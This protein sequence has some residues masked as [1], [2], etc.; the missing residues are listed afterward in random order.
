MI[1]N[2]D[3]FKNYCYISRLQGLPGLN[4]GVLLVAVVRWWLTEDQRHLTYL[5]PGMK[6]NSWEKEHPGSLG[7][8]LNLYVGCLWGLSRMLASAYQISYMQAQG[9]KDGCFQREKETEIERASLWKLLSS[10]WP[11][12]GSCQVLNIIFIRTESLNPVYIQGEDNY[13]YGYVLKLPQSG[14]LNISDP[15]LIKVK[16]SILNNPYWEI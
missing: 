13:I 9:S 1:L 4:F 8:F 14:I 15:S 5:V 12:L 2:N 11:S 6:R 16:P 10:L 3:S 7:I